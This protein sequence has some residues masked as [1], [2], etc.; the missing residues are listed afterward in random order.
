MSS[1]GSLRYANERSRSVTR[2]LHVVAE[3]RLLQHAT[4]GAQQPRTVR[5]G[6]RNAGQSLGEGGLDAGVGLAAEP[7]HQE[8]LDHRVLARAV[9]ERSQHRMPEP[10]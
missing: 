2:V 4:V 3:E 5:V 10:P 6:D 7:V 1:S 9:H 8:R